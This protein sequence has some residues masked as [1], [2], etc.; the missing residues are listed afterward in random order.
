MQAKQQKNILLIISGSVAAYKSLDLIR[1]LR[2]GGYCVKTILTKGGEQFITPL[3][4]SSLSGENV[5]TDLFSLKDEVEMGHIRLSREADLILI[6]PA[7]ANIISEIAVG[8]A[9]DLATATI[10]ASNKPVMIA[11][12]MNHKMWESSATKRNISTLIND[13][14]LLIHPTEG[15]MACGEYGVGRMAELETIVSHVNGFFNNSNSLAGISAIVTAGGTREMI[16]PVRYIGNISSGKQGLAIAN[17]LAKRGANVCLVS[18]THQ[19]KDILNK[20]I[21]LITAT[22]ADDMMQKVHANIKNCDIAIFSAAVADWKPETIASNKIKKSDEPPTIKLTQNDDILKSV[23][24]LD[25]KIRPKIVV[26]FAAETENLIE[27]AS[28]KLIGKGCDMIIAN[29]VSNGRV[30]GCDSNK[31]VIITQNEQIES[32]EASKEVI[33]ELIIDEITKLHKK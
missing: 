8:S 24:S 6:A 32:N 19:Q 31:I 27:N 3:A 1:E 14:V 30:L 17:E 20:R 23:A 26:G 10:L 29:D 5:Y 18:S 4:V 7:S 12:A 9:K 33:A 15:E 28:K 11:P 2:R 21:S 22:S 13:G 16:D 25:K